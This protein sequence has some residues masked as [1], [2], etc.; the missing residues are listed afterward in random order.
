L[1][2]SRS[3]REN[4]FA[5]IRSP[6][7]IVLW[8]LVGWQIGAYG[9]L[10]PPGQ[11]ALNP[12]IGAEEFRMTQGAGLGSLE[13][14]R[15]FSPPDSLTFFG[16]QSYYHTDSLFYRTSNRLAVNAW[17][18]AFGVSW[19]PY[20]TFAWTPRLTVQPEFVRFARASRV[21]Y[22]AQA[23]ALENRVFLSD[24]H[25]FWWNS[26][27]VGQRY[28]GIRTGVGELYKRVEFQNSLNA[29]A[30]P[31]QT[32]RWGL[33]GAAGVSWRIAHP[34]FEERLES[35]LL[36]S[37]LFSASQALL[38]EPFIRGGYS[39]FPNDGPNLIDRRDILVSGG[40]NC[41]W[42]VSRQASLTAAVYWQGNY[43]SAAA[44]DYQILP[45]I[46]LGA[47]FSF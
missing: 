19:V 40:L 45:F 28:E 38:F 8:L 35:F 34:A 23:M 6:S 39:Y 12:P 18:A 32:G 26:S 44:A 41:A 14:V 11:G 25:R 13:R 17:I 43:S 21:D 9:Q 47:R 46:T 42:R 29:L 37:I 30:P 7:W 16:S 31:G 1:R 36:G 2:K 15:R 5:D 4:P 24:S 22:N 33:H 10:L 27:V 20:S 3:A